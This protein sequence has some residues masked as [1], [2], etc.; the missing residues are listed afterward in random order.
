MK[1]VSKVLLVLLVVAVIWPSAI[2]I[3]TSRSGILG[4]SSVGG[5]DTTELVGGY[6]SIPF[7]TG[8]TPGTGQDPFGSSTSPVWLIVRI[9]PY[10][11]A[12]IGLFAVIGLM[13][14]GDVI[15]SVILAALVIII[16]IVGLGLIGQGFP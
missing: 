10:I 1:R 14:S 11:F 2:T 5:S 8:A 6:F 13:V 3:A 12:A 16:T 4:Y 9:L 7:I 15:A